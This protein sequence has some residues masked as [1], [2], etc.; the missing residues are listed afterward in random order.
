MLS[1]GWKKS[2]TLSHEVTYSQ[3]FI[4]TDLHINH[5]IHYKH[6]KPEYAREKRKN[7]VLHLLS[8]YTSC[9]RRN[10][11]AGV[12]TSLGKHRLNYTGINLFPQNIDRTARAS[13]FLRETSTELY[14]H[15]PFFAKHQPN[16][17]GINLSP[18]NIDRTVRASTFLRETSTELRGHQPSSAKHRPNFA[19]IN[20]FSR[21]I[22]RTARASTF[23]RETSTELY[24]HQP[25]EPVLTYH[26]EVKS[27][28]AGA[29]HGLF[30]NE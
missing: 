4:L 26:T 10:I 7:Y 3:S 12:S 23:F 27:L 13:T 21:N 2:Q 15:Q 17:A 29:G 22:D 16:C 30:C 14:G 19:G 28:G 5:T 8:D 24:V 11:D 1:N 18:R 9:V 20:L 25:S 6:I